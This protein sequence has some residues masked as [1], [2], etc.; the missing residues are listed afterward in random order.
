MNEERLEKTKTFLVSIQFPLFSF[1]SGTLMNLSERALEQ[2]I[3]MLFQDS[4]LETILLMI[5]KRE[6]DKNALEN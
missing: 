2:E 3:R 1:R 6:I 4:N 5:I